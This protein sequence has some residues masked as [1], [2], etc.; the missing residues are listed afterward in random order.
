MILEAKFRH[1]INL[2][3]LFLPISLC[4]STVLVYSWSLIEADVENYS[5]SC[6]L[7]GLSAIL[8]MFEEPVYFLSTRRLSAKNKSVSEASMLGAGYAVLCFMT[9]FLVD[10]VV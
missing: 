3:W 5:L 6:A 10:D 4:L 7:I 2:T 8:Q 1:S 9:S